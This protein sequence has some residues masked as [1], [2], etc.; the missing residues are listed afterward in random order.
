MKTLADILEDYYTGEP[1]EIAKMHLQ[2][3][4]E[5]INEAGGFVGGAWGPDDIMD[6][7][8]APQ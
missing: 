8:E 7:L 3:L 6:N 5:D 4:L 2:E 1:F